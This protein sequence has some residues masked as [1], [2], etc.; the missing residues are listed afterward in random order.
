MHMNAAALLSSLSLDHAL[1]KEKGLFILHKGV[2]N[3]E[4]ILL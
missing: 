3:D 4:K 1:K 2:L